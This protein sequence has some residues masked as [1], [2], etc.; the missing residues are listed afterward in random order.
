MRVV[1]ASIVLG[2]C[3]SGEAREAVPP[4]PAA[5]ATVIDSIFPLAEALRRFRADIPEV[6]ALA[7]G[8]DSRDDLVRR[9]VR[10]LETRDTSAIRDLVLSRA[11]YAWLYYPTSS[12]S[13]EPYYQMPQ[14][15]WFLSFEDSRKGI[16][17]ALRRFGG[18]DL[19]YAGYA[20]PDSALVDGGLRF[21]HRC[22]I[23]LGRAGVPKQLRLFGSI[24][25]RDG[26]FKFYS[27]AND[28]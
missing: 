14:L 22:T 3:A 10:A 23:A 25:E 5:V 27:Y 24:V 12:F 1:L 16:T 7:G 18:G 2:G 11:E 28:L 15:N 21:W 17:R 20:C 8:A 13:R 4:D 9:F 6:Q 19:Q 26:Q